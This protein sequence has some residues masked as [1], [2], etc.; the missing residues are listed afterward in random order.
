M[1]FDV[2]EIN[3]AKARVVLKDGREVIVITT[4]GQAR[5]YEFSEYVLCPDYID[6][7]T[8][9]RNRVKP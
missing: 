1:N 8:E 4:L 6:V 9:V 5:G 7:L 3:G 2:R